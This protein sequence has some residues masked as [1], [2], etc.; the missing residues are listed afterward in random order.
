MQYSHFL[1]LWKHYCS[2]CEEKVQKAKGPNTPGGCRQ[3]FCHCHITIYQESFIRR[4]QLD[5]FVQQFAMLEHQRLIIWSVVAISKFFDEVW[6]CCALVEAQWLKLPQAEAYHGCIHQPWLFKS[7]LMMMVTSRQ[8]MKEPRTLH[9]MSS[10]ASKTLTTNSEQ[11]I[12]IFSNSPTSSM[13]KQG[14]SIFYSGIFQTFWHIAHSTHS[15]KCTKLQ[16]KLMA[17][18]LEPFLL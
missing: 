15:C 13:H 18:L 3:V 1:L 5:I 6:H 14:K 2:L 12:V 9:T 7:G 16:A 8:T 10:S 11:A 4:Y 17:L